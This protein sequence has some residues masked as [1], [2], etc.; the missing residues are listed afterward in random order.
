MLPG[1]KPESAMIAV[2]PLLHEIIP[3]GA[4][5]VALLEPVAPLVVATMKILRALR[6]SR[7]VCGDM[8][9]WMSGKYNGAHG[10]QLPGSPALRRIFA[11]S[12][13]RITLP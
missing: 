13:K 12:Y 4:T 8:K 7:I 10:S 2:T 11:P 1:L 9:I 3:H 6:S 5:R